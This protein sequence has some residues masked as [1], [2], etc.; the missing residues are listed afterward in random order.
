MPAFLTSAASLAS[1][2]R[3][4][5]PSSSAVLPRGVRPWALS[6]SPWE[7]QWT[8]EVRVKSQAGAMLGLEMPALTAD[9]K[10]TDERKLDAKDAVK[11]VLEGI[12]GR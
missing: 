6:C 5:V 12:F 10:K 11:G 2:V 9:D 1:C 4:A 7:P 3:V 8:V